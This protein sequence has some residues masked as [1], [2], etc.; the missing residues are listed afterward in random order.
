MT[1]PMD[2]MDAL[3]LLLFPSIHLITSGRNVCER[4]NFMWLQED[5][6][7]DEICLKVLQCILKNADTPEGFIFLLLF[8]TRKVLKMVKPSSDRK[9]IILLAF[10][11]FIRPFDIFAK[12]CSRM[13]TAIAFSRQN[14]DFKIQRRGRQRER[15]KNNGFNKQNNNFTRASHFFVHFFPVFARLRRENA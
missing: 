3:L 7:D 11:I 4:G 12:N 15:K 8:F 2:L 13:A 1:Y 9:M 6:Y 10:D 14:R 5:D